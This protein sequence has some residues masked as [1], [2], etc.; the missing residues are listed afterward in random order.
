MAARSEVPLACCEN[1]P[2]YT[3]FCRICGRLL[4]SE[5]VLTNPETGDSYEII[6][7]L[8]QGGM[9]TTYLIFNLQNDRLAVL[10]EIDADLSRKAKAR[11]LFLREA[12]VLAELRHPGIPRFYDFFC[13]EDRYYL[14]MEM[15][16]GLTLEQLQPRSVSQAVGWML[17]VCAVLTYLHERTPP[18]IHRDLK[19]ANMI[20]RYN[21]REVVLIDYGAVKEFSNRQ[22]TRIATPGYG[23]PEQSQ[24]RP[25][26]QSDIYGVA[27]T[28][29]FLLTRQ[30]PGN[31]YNIR[32][33]RLLGLDA[34]GIPAD[35][36]AIIDVATAYQPQDRYRDCRAFAAALQPFAAS[37]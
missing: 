23:P 15:I 30:F 22:G 2:G 6:S 16:Y 31:L 10:K 18:V 27:M 32:Q 33:R 4:I 34:A 35:L 25:C 11:E 1:N 5:G 29:V 8:A 13:T 28:L 36:I 19:P 7:T 21:P 37:G 26:I 9:S 24:G 12:R 20:L 17:E 3:R 14:V